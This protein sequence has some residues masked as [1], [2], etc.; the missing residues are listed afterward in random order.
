MPLPPP[1][2]PAKRRVH[3]KRSTVTAPTPP[4]APINTIASVTIQSD[5]RDGRH[6][7]HAG[8]GCYRR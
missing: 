7:V 2:Y 3:R 5:L 1:I 4:P 8:H 6:R